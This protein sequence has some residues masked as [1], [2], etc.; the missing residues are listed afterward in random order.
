MTFPELIDHWRAGRHP[1]TSELIQLV[2]EQFEVTVPSLPPKKGDAARAWLSAVKA[3]APDHLTARL[4]QLERF[5]T[6]TTATTLWPLFEALARLPPDPRLATLATR[7]L[8]GDLRLALTAKLQRRLLDCVETHGDDSHFR[9]LELGLALHLHLLQDG[10]AARAVR[11]MQRGLAL[12]PVGPELPQAERARLLAAAWAPAPVAPKPDPLRAVYAAP[13]DDARR[14]VLADVL[15]EQGDPRGEFISLQLAQASP[16][17]QQALLEK[18]QKEW[19]GS[20]ADITE[21]KR[22]TPLFAGGF[23]SELSV[24]AVKRGQFLLAADAP[25]WATVTR[26]RRGLQRLSPAMASLAHPGPTPLEVIKGWARDAPGVPLRS[27]DVAA[28]PAL[29]VDVLREAPHP[30]PWV[31]ARFG[32]WEA[33]RQLRD[34]L[35]SFAELPGL[36]RLRLG[37]EA[38]PVL[39]AL[40]KEMG[41]EWLPASLAQLDLVDDAGHVLRLQR[42][43]RRWALTLLDFRGTRAATSEWRDALS[44]LR[45][46][47]PSSVRVRFSALQAEENVAHFEA[48]LRGF[49][50]PVGVTADADPPGW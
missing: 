22:D 25:E 27:I 24:R 10:L 33:S 37:A 3:E 9:S 1:S 16:K 6:T 47:T 19:L 48:L 31:A 14:Q 49:K 30:V 39:P 2:G 38:F 43:G 44:N 32:E 42:D 26:V 15:L 4:A 45:W 50:M 23:V 18:H 13:G 17:R 29:V 8:V 36:E 41:L 20:I 46:L 7:Y 35:A 5:A 12:K 28:P 34:G 40:L 21:F 11:L